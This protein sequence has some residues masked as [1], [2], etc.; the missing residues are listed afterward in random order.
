MFSS[1]LSITFLSD[2]RRQISFP[3]KDTSGH[4][5]PKQ[6]IFP[7]NPCGLG[8]CHFFGPCH[9][10]LILLVCSWFEFHTKS[11]PLPGLCLGKWWKNYPNTCW[12]IT[13]SSFVAL[14][15]ASSTCKHK[16]LCHSIS[17]IY[18]LLIFFL[19]LRCH[20]LLPRLLL[21]LSTTG[22]DPS[23]F[24]FNLFAFTQLAWH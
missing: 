3:S 13:W 2:F 5:R 21:Q 16:G 6:S 10:P 20:H 11:V 7:S 19:N 15:S 1:F 22:Q 18:H 23:L 14:P 9:L 4:M 24:T 8:D 17:V 12:G